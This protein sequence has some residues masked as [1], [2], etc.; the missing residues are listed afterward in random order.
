MIT[1]STA[2]SQS[3]NLIADLELPI[4]AKV[5]K[6]FQGPYPREPTITATVDEMNRHR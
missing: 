3:D 4:P 5:I 2:I 1:T 6:K